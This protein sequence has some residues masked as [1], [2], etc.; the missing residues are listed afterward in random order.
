MNNNTVTVNVEFK[1]NTDL[2][3]EECIRI[4]DSVERNFHSRQKGFI[5]TE[6]AKGSNGKWV[7]I[8][9]WATKEDFMA[10]VKLMMKDHS[11][12]EFRQ[13]IDPKSVKMQSLEQIQLWNIN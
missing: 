6:L 7:M 10:I 9:H 5:D 2:P 13:A 8:Q 12:E 1:F 11:T 3:D 4:I